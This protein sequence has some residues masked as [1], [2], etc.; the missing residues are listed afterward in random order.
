M[1]QNQSLFF[2]NKKVQKNIYILYKLKVP[3]NNKC[4]LILSVS[5]SINMSV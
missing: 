1:A 3:S 2:T 4:T 5:Y